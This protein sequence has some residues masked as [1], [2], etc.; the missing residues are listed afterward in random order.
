MLTR[1]CNFGAEQIREATLES[2]VENEI[3]REEGVLLM[4]L[5][6]EMKD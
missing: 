3:I 1:G 6:G 4:L 2:I 5:W